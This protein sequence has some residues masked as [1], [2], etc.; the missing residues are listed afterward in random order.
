M[1]SLSL[2]FFL[3]QHPE[4]VGQAPLLYQTYRVHQSPI[5]AVKLNEHSLISGV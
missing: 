5:K 2:V 4:N 1:L 3:G